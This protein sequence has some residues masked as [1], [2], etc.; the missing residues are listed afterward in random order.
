MLLIVALDPASRGLGQAVDQ[1][2]PP[3][4]WVDRQDQRVNLLIEGSGLPGLKSG[5]RAGRS[6]S[7]G[8]IRATTVAL[9]VEVTIPG[10]PQPGRCE[11]EVAADGRTIRRG[12]ETVARPARRPEPFGPDDVIYLVMPD[13]FSDGDPGNNEP[14]PGDRLYD[15]RDTHAYHGGDFAGLRQRLPYLVE[16]GVTAIWLTP[17]Y[18]PAPYWFPAN[19]G[20]RPKKMADFHGY[21]PVDF[22]DTTSVR[23]AGR[24]SGAGRRAHRLGLKVIQDQVLGYTGP[25]HRWV[26]RPPAG[27]WFHGPMDHPRGCNFRFDARPIPTRE[28]TTAGG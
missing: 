14:E 12:W 27:G 8:S 21:C 24:L 23:L 20:G 7:S 11:L 26:A 17:I 22:Y 9:F 16:L 28:R 6:A 13:R 10:G 19:L 4:W 5:A 2:D 1:I 18:R 3:S 15:R 25:K